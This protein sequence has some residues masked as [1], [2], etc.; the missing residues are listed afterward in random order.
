MSKKTRAQELLELMEDPETIALAETYP[1][2]FFD[3]NPELD[4]DPD[5]EGDIN[6][7]EYLQKF[8]EAVDEDNKKDGQSK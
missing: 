8:A 6:V 1:K 5:A 7:D 4:F 3:D 2:P